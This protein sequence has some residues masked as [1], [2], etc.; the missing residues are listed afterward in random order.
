MSAGFRSAQAY[1]E[2]KNTEKG[3][4][5]RVALDAS[6]QRVLGLIP[7]D[8]PE[9]GDLERLADQARLLE[10]WSLLVSGN[11]TQAQTF[12][13]GQL[14][15]TSASGGAA[16]KHGAELGLAEATLAAG[17]VRA[18]QI[19]FAR[20]SALDYVDRDRTA[21]AMLGMAR[22]AKKLSDGDSRADARRW[23]EAVIAD[24]G[25]TPAALL[26]REEL[27]TN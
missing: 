7:A 23:L 4:E 21:R 3:H 20:V 9:R 22:C 27:S 18:A 8:D 12:F 16:L 25:D 17:E 24:F 15:L 14:S 10:G 5:L 6:L 13:R 11:A 1:L 26:A 2:A 19:L